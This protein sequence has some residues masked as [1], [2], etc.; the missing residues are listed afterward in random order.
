MKPLKLIKKIT[1][2][3]IGKIHYFHP[4]KFSLCAVCTPHILIMYAS[5]CELYT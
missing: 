4:V 1:L 3:S 5:D 2:K